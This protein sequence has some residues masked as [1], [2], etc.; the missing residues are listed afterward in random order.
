MSFEIESVG[1]V[2]AGA[3]GMVL[4]EAMALAGVPTV[5]VR[6]GGGRTA[7]VVDRVKRSLAT[8]GRSAALTALDRLSITSDRGAVNDCGLVIEAVL[9]DLVTKREVLADLDASLPP[10]AIV[11]TSSATLRLADL[12]ASLR[13]DRMVGF[14]LAV[15]V[16]TSTRVAIGYTARTDR[17][18]LAAVSR[19]VARIGRAAVPVREARSG[20]AA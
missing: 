19:L 13:D 6:A 16:R 20:R 11:A 9:E 4:A 10:A 7:T 3:M 12:A 8:R 15:P 1:I 18:V 2:G 14:H 17:D 5:L